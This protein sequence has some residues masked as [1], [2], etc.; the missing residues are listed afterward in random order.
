MAGD[1]LRRM[2]ARC[3]WQASKKGGRDALRPPT[4]WAAA[5]CRHRSVRSICNANN[6]GIMSKLKHT[7]IINKASREEKTGLVHYWR[8]AFVSKWGERFSVCCSCRLIWVSGNRFSLGV[9]KNRLRELEE[10]SSV[11]VS[12]FFDWG[13][14]TC[15]NWVMMTWVLVFFTHAVI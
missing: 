9:F 3:R 8:K 12:M 1:V 11:V 14:C 4:A 6:E 15:V 10:G 5:C 2:E 7:L 13:M